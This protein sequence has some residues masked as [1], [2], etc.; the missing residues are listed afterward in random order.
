MK[1]YKRFAQLLCNSVV[2]WLVYIIISWTVGILLLFA[3]NLFA[4]IKASGSFYGN[5]SLVLLLSQW[6]M[7]NYAVLVTT[8]SAAAAIPVLLRMYHTDQIQRGIF[9]PVQKLKSRKRY[10]LALGFSAC[11]AGN[12][13]I[14]MSQLGSWFPGYEE[15]AVLIDRSWLWIKLLGVGVLVPIAEELVFRAMLFHRLRDRYSFWLAAVI[16]SAAFAVFHGNIVQGVYAAGSGVILA[17]GYEQCQS[18]LAPLLLHCSMNL[19][20]ILWNQ[21]V[22]Q[23]PFIQSE[24][25]FYSAT[26]MALTICCYCMIHLKNREHEK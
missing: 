7:D 26:L 9:P 8:L 13:L 11:I 20:S 4:L 1:E 12:N 21:A 25:L 6:Y 22:C 15:T 3:E 5:H 17:Y 2:P 19:T 16:A 23:F 24:P 18:L 14:K 10:L